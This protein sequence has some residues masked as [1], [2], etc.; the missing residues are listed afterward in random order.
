MA[1]RRQ[2]RPRCAPPACAQE[3]DSIDASMYPRCIHWLLACRPQQAGVR[4]GSR[5]R[6]MRAGCLGAGQGRRRQ[7]PWGQLLRA[8]HV[9]CACQWLCGGPRR[10]LSAG[11][12]VHCSWAALRPTCASTQDSTLATC[13]HLLSGGWGMRRQWTWVRITIRQCTTVCNSTCTAALA[14][15][16]Q[17]KTVIKHHLGQYTCLCVQCP[18]Q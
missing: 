6:S 16:E 13:Q 9:V 7:G 3:R 18:P 5:H 4:N 12:G 8:C 17:N 10:R 14:K 11:R 2:G 15:S 1:W